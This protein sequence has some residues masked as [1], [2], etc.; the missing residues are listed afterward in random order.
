MQPGF[1]NIFGWPI[2]SEFVFGWLG[3]LI[4][5]SGIVNGALDTSIITDRI[6]LP[7]LH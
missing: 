2:R 4:V 7:H 5:I 3:V 1:T 6:R